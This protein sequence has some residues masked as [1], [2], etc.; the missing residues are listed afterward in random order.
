MT[1]PVAPRRKRIV[2]VDDSESYCDLWER[3]LLERYGVERVSVE[4]YLHPLQAMPGID[5]S[6]DLLLLDLEMPMIDGRKFLEFAVS[7]GVDRRRIIVAS[8]RH[9]D[10]LHDLFPTGDCLAVINKTEPKQQEAFLMILDGVMR[11]S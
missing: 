1:T 2:I 10:L 4:K 8:G 7:R 6:V 3:F 5:H 9:A 11:R